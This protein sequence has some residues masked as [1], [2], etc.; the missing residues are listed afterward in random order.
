MMQ[1]DGRTDEEGHARVNIPRAQTKAFK[2]MRR[3]IRQIERVEAKLPFRIVRDEIGDLVLESIGAMI[4]D[5][6]KVVIRGG[7]KVDGAPSIVVQIK[8]EP[9]GK[10][11]MVRYMPIASA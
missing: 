2:E 6:D 8:L 10:H 11:A 3:L 4:E 1:F 5:D 7:E 9:G